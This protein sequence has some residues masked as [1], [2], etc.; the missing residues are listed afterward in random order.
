[1]KCVCAIKNLSRCRPF[2]CCVIAPAIVLLAVAWAAADKSIFDDDWTPPPR[3][4]PATPAPTTRPIP[5]VP[6]PAPP[7][8]GAPRIVRPSQVPVTPV[9]PPAVP[10]PRI[11]SLPAA[12]YPV[13]AVADQA[14]SRR[15]MA[16]AFSKELADSSPAARRTLARKLLQ[17]AAK[18]SDAPTD[19]FV[20]LGGAIQSAVEAADL[21]L[22]LEAA[23]QLADSYDLDGLSLKASVALK[24]PPKAYAANADNVPAG[25][26]LL[27]PLESAEDF[28]TASRLVTLLQQV[29]GV[30][31]LLR[32]A[33]PE[34]VKGIDE[35]R[36]ARD[37]L[38]PVLQKLK[39]APNDPSANLAVGRYTALLRG[40]WEQGL[41]LLAKGNDPTLAALAKAALAEPADADARAALAG[42]WWD[43]AQSSIGRAK[44]T[45]LARAA[46]DYREAMPG[47][48]GLGTV[49]AEKRSAEADAAVTAA[50]RIKVRSAPA[51]L[52]PGLVA[53]LYLDTKFS[54]L[55]KK[56][57][58]R[59]ICFQWQE[60]PPDPDMSGERFSIR[61]T[62]ELRIPI[63]GSY[64]FFASVDDEVEIWLD[65]QSI[66]AQHE[67]TKS[68]KAQVKL[69]GGLHQVRIDYRNIGGNGRLMLQWAQEDGLAKQGLGR[70]VL[71]HEAAAAADAEPATPGWRSDPI[72]G[73]GGGDPFFEPAPA[74]T[75]LAGFELSER[76]E[77][78]HSIIKSVRAI[79]RGV[80]GD[81]PGKQFGQPQGDV[82]RL[83][84]KPGYAVGM[85]Q[86]HAGGLI[87]GLSLHFM[88]LRGETLDPSDS[89]DSDFV[90]GPG[91]DKIDVG[92]AKPVIGIYGFATRD[93]HG[94]GLITADGAAPSAA[95]VTPPRLPVAPVKVT[96]IS[97]DYGNGDRTVSL[98]EKIQAAL[99]A[100]PFTPIDAGSAWGGDP[101]PFTRKSLLL[102]YRIG[103]KTYNTGVA[104]NHICFIPP[105][106]EAGV[107]VVGGSVPFKIIAAR[108]GADKAWVDATDAIRAQAVD[109]SMP[110]TVRNMAGG[111][112]LRQGKEKNLVV[113]YEFQGR[114][115]A[116]IAREGNGM[117]LVPKE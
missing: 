75:V 116:R 70:D 31:P 2:A 82:V 53:E 98:A 100:D 80:S 61:W 117:T 3:S 96:I 38:G 34:H 91:G 42:G 6:I 36:A 60:S 23:D 105:I 48:S 13:P 88:R 103:D 99:D 90:G 39:A 68:A 46:D 1:M 43:L 17:E 67:A 69:S 49:V 93:C 65:G 37:R 4:G 73:Q 9:L 57:I 22:A 102:S 63:T 55:A 28:T 79:Y 19:Q 7:S 86:A 45:L 35:L 11:G 110:F 21:P 5:V 97:A 66:L 106:P 77:N 95:A 87:N 26:A 15:L 85:V 52:L 47:L 59:Q 111:K 30:E 71:W 40:D 76:G 92:E 16:E 84:A 41:P 113:Y 8:A 109:P 115:Y 62:G 74:R 51:G 94:L 12:R 25:L 56:R 50:A 18:I 14:K 33:L 114:R 112:D 29:P 10:A 32:T 101:A 72:G 58:D 108:Y 27:D 89:Y 81:L 107:A 44:T 54:R 20:V 83:L 64:T 78:G 104:E 24:M